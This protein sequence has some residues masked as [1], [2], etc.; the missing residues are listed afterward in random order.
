[1]DII[2]DAECAVYR[3]DR[4]FLNSFNFDRDSNINFPSSNL[5]YIAKIWIIIITRSYTADAVWN[6]QPS[7]Q[8]TNTVMLNS[9]ELHVEKVS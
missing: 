8:P 7:G 1:M 2:L 9:N 6:R 3:S 5:K 4:L